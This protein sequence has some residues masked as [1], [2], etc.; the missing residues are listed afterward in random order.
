MAI[1]WSFRDVTIQLSCL[2]LTCLVVSCHTVR[3]QPTWESLDTRPLPDWYDE[4]KFGIFIH[5]GVFSVPSYVSEWFWWDWQGAREKKAVHFMQENYPPGFTYADFASQ[6]KAEFFNATQWAQ[7][8]HEAGARYIVFVSKHV[9]GFTNWPSKYS[10]NWNS[11]DV[12]PKRDLVGELASAIRNNTDIRFGLYHCLY[13]WFNPLFLQDKANNFTTQNFV[14]AKTMPEL[15]ELVNTYR[16]DII[17]SDGPTEA[18]DLYWKS[19]DFIAWLYNDSPVRDTV[20]IN[21][22]WGL[23]DACYHGGFYTCTDRYNPGYLVEHKWENA[24]SVDRK[25]WGYRRDTNINDVLTIEQLITQLITTVSTNGNLLMNVGPGSDG[26]IKPIY[27]ERLLQVGSWL[28]VNGE[29]IYGSRP[30]TYQN[31]TIT[32]GV[33]YTQN[34]KTQ[35]AVIYAHLLFWPR[36]NLTLGAPVPSVKTTVTL[37][38][39]AG[40]AFQWSTHTTPGLQIVVPN[41]HMSDMPCQWAWVLKLT[42]ILN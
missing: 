28:K 26:V 37:I 40:S 7:L 17:W 8:F 20:V 41:I 27:Q 25:S 33:W 21:D 35:P 30:W 5:W 9:E 34:N 22:R 14:N 6:F 1:A 32:E 24:M 23:G 42:D 2:V 36:T 4:A 3:Y 18:D 16:P 39:Y 29:A 12:G 13:E 10:W 11:L 15:Y 38:G 31:D 19:K